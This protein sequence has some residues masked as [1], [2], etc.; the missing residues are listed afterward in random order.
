[1]GPGSELRLD[2]SP[3]ADAPPWPQLELVAELGFPG[4]WV[5]AAPRVAPGPGGTWRLS[6][7][8][9]GVVLSATLR[10]AF[11]LSAFDAI[12]LG[13]AAA[14]PGEVLV[15]LWDGPDLVGL[16]RSQPV[17]VSD[18]V[19]WLHLPAHVFWQ[20]DRRADRLVLKAHAS[21]HRVDL[22]SLALL[23]Q[24]A[25]AVLPNPA[26][27]P[28]LVDL[29]GDA[30]R[31]EGLDQE[32]ELSARFVVPANGRLS[33][34]HTWEPQHG[35]GDATPLLLV[36][37]LAGAQ[38]VSRRVARPDG[39]GR[40][41]RWAAVELDL[42]ELA[43]R[44]A[45]LRM[46]LAPAVE[47]PSAC[48]I[49]ELSVWSPAAAP[50]TLVLITSDTHRAD[51]LGAAPGSVDVATPTLD[52]L[53][54]RGVLFSDC[55][56]TT[57]VT[58]PSHAALL[59]GLHPAE[60]GIL[61]NSLPLGERAATLAEAF[62]AAG[63]RTAAVVSARHLGHPTSG[64]GQGFDRMSWPD[65]GGS[66]SAEDSLP[67]AQAAL[68]AADG[69]PLFLWVHLFDAHGPYKPPAR[70][71]RRYWP[72]DSDP[73][74]EQLPEPEVPASVLPPELSG[75]RDFSWPAAAYRGEVSRLDEALAPLLAR[76]RVADGLVALTADHGESFGQHGIWFTHAGLYPES[77]HVP[78]VIAFPGAS[79]GRVSDTPV[80]HLDLAATLLELAGVDARGVPGR[81][82]AALARGGA[83]SSGPRFA[84]SAHGF[85]AS[86]TDDGW[87]LVLH[88]RDQR[89]RQMTSSFE[90]HQVQLYDLRADPGCTQDLWREELPRARAL[91]R[92]LV[93]WL[94]SRQD[95][96]LAGELVQDAE[97][98]AQLRELGYLEDTS[99]GPS[100]LWVSDS[101][102]WC[103]HFKAEAGG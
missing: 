86:V 90:R 38:R 59:S 27:P 11:E 37:V 76:G 18:D 45:E 97:R 42:S 30:R 74:D 88:L 3:P 16:T 95:L 89:Q 81:S 72:D 41:A 46:W 39:V 79:A 24:P 28:Q 92:G 6:D 64:L 65:G 84:L 67:L 9:G 56:A 75:L 98:A 43:G 77:I 57:N 44:E 53:A 12:R 33:F 60:T 91:R 52:A 26:G 93:T 35:S 22:Q 4:A 21:V 94:A 51:H 61:H 101:C 102:S 20:R 10:G 62:A 73:Y 50:S 83:V 1:V 29:W 31:A 78:L 63:W 36:E 40:E 68:D 5:A 32:R 49:G 23:R 96:D 17:I 82:F 103:A 48:A 100:E 13:V 87:H 55:L 47:L 19:A 71:A 99:A 66:R 85:S 34:V 15:E 2:L 14:G 7:P 8:A 70:W 54:A 80:G 58:N 69:R 25:G